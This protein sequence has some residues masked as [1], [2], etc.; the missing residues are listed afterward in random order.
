MD[1]PQSPAFAIGT[2]VQLA[3]RPAYLKTADPMPMLRPPDLV[4]NGE[5]GQVVSLKPLGQLAVRFRR[6]TFL[7]D[8]VQLCA[9]VAADPPAE[10]PNG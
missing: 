4:D 6:G 10:R 9:A 3:E 7:L 8:A 1:E 2:R 5:V